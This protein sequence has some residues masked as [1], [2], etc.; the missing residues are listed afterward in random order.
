MAQ[1]PSLTSLNG[2]RVAAEATNLHRSLY[3]QSS[4]RRFS[5]L[6][7]G[8]AALSFIASVF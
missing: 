1:R 6:A 7:W 2:R 4:L 8:A 5:F 3:P